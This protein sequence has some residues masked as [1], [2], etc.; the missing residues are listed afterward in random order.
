MLFF[1]RNSLFWS[2]R[3]LDNRLFEVPMR[4]PSLVVLAVTALLLG[5]SPAGAA[6]YR[7]IDDAGNE[8][9]TNDPGRVPD[10]F[11]ERSTLVDASPGQVNVGEQPVS[12]TGSSASPE[13][14]RDRDGRGETWWRRRAEKLRAELRTLEDEY[15]LVL[16]EERSLDAGPAGGG[17]GTKARSFARKKAKLEQKITHARRRLESELPDEARRAGALPGWLRE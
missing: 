7:W 10:R 13:A 15:D 3:V 6:L 4:S 14:L 17:R 16:L 1:I 5:P 2:L 8:N 11:R 12:A 9:F